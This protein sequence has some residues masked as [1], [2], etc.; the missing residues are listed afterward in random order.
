[1]P[2]ETE[3]TGDHS[4]RLAHLFDIRQLTLGGI[5]NELVLEARKR[6]VHWLARTPFSG[7]CEAGW[8]VDVQGVC[9]ACLVRPMGRRSG[10]GGRRSTGREGFGMRATQDETPGR[11]HWDMRISHWPAWAN[12]S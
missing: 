9:G 10:L 4:E 8:L 2:G 1:M 5:A 3:A 7:G 6:G 11:L 12:L